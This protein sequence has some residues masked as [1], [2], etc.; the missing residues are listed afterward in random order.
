MKL[1]DCHF[2]VVDP[3]FPLIPN[4][5]FLPDSFTCADYLR[6]T[7]RLGVVGGCVVS[8]SFNG[9]DQTY[10]RAALARLGQGFIG[11]TQLPSTVSDEEIA[12]LHASGVRGVR[13]N[14][15]RGG[16]V[17][18]VEL[19]RLAFR[20]H[21]L[22]G[23]HAEIYEDAKR[24]AA[25]KDWLLAL[26]ALSIDHLGLSLEGFPS[27]LALAERGVRVKASGFGRVNFDV[28]DALRE[29][30]RANPDCLMFGSDLPST[31]AARAFADSDVDLVLDSFDEAAAAKI[32]FGNAAAFYRVDTVSDPS[33]R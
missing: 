9:S 20:V 32:L 2:H 25:M 33:R 1:F 18:P 16:A 23:W 19:Q 11:I 28:R 15:R 3:R 22:V 26:P 31:R 21:R 14:L 6:R 10:L 7:A 12:A 24:L 27:L 13:F 29:L 5:G 8:G 17:N 4:E 30:W